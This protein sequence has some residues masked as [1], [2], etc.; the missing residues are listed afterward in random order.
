[1]QQIVSILRACGEG[2]LGHAVVVRGE[3]GIGKTRLSEELERTAGNMGF[4]THRGL[5]LDFGVESGRDAIRTIFRDLLN[6]NPRASTDELQQASQRAVANGIVTEGL[7]IHVNDVLD[8][9]QPERLRS[10]YDAMDMERRQQGRA[11]AIAEILAWAAREQPRLLIVEDVH[12]ARP[13][14]LRTLAQVVN[15]ILECPVTLVITSRVEGDPLDG[16]W[17]AAV[18]GIPLTTVDLSL[19]RAEDARAICETVTDDPDAVAG[20]VSR[21]GGNPLFLEQLLR[22]ANEGPDEKVPGTIQSLVQSVVDRLSDEDRET[23]QA[24]SIVGQRVDP[25]LLR[26]LIDGNDGNLRRLVERKILRPMGQDYLFVHALIRDAIYAS[27]LTPERTALH[28]RAADWFKERDRKLNAEHLAL[29]GAVDAPAAF[30]LAAREEFAKYNYENAVALIE[31][32]LSLATTA[33]DIV[34]LRLLAGETWHAF[35]RMAEAQQAFSDAEREAL[36]GT[37][38]CRA[39]IGLAEVKRVTD[40]LDGAFDDLRACGGERGQKW[41][42]CGTGAPAFPAGQSVFPEGRPRELPPRA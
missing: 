40:D 30:L 15:A 4:T 25:A 6:V 35:G 28:R 17:R 38:R 18:A 20:F 10:R 1:M 21:A 14:L 42:D 24:A 23:V 19:L 34:A 22:H 7:E 13:P 37:D 27:L 31:R 12:W 9:P 5:V 26:F 3:A 2:S 16:V 41:A 32:G 33:A 39:Q 11:A 8:A 29:A 36:S